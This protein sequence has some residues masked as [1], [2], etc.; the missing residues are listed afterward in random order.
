MKTKI[1]F[2]RSYL[3]GIADTLEQAVEHHELQQDKSKKYADKDYHDMLD[4]PPGVKVLV[5]YTY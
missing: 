5:M 2:P 3:N 1:L 4:Y